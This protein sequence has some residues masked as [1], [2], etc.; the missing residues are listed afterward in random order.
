LTS[1]NFHA[2]VGYFKV[3][4]QKKAIWIAY[5]LFFLMLFV[6]LTYQ[7]IKAALLLMVSGFLVFTTLLR[8]RIALHPAI[9]MWTLFMVVTGL[10]FMLL[11]L[12]NDG[13]GAL[14]SGTVYVL[15]P[16][17]YTLLIAGI[18]NIE[19][20]EGIFRILLIATIAIG[21]YSLSFILYRT[22]RLPGFLYVRL[23]QG[24]A[25]GFVHG[26]IAYRLH[27]L[28]SLFFIVPFL[29]T[30]LLVWPRGF[31]MPVS[32][33][34]LWIAFILGMVSVLLSG[35]RALW[36]VVAI[37]PFLVFLF[38]L[39]VISNYRLANGRSVI[40]VLLGVSTVALV[41]YYYL[42]TTYGFSVV[43]VA[44]RFL[45]G[46]DVTAYRGT[47]VRRK[48]L[49]ALLQGWWESP[50][51]GTGHGTAASYVRG[52]E[53]SWTYELTYISLLFHTGI[54]GF[55]IYA[56]GVVWIIWM[57][58]KVVRSKGKLGNFAFPVLIGTSCFLIGSATNPYI[59]T[60]DYVWIIFLPIALI[61]LWLLSHRTSDLLDS[62]T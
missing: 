62:E 6:P 17:V 50:L 10:G 49:S 27:S 41:T 26:Q 20:V 31:E 7:I 37:T 21:M 14:R 60:F 16:L 12:V 25:L 24:Q 11:G 2:S 51:V 48:Q 19:I 30:I 1:F 57:G 58:L 4:M 9:L 28:N 38:R 8:R 43:D 18:R 61:N 46:F 44:N 3:V 40:K 55:L 22:G 35:R 5:F 36:L 56:S 45:E 23:D 33:F 13:P 15:W 54:L 47:L 29:I 39:F 32:R 42:H 59:V 53:N 34:W 52:D